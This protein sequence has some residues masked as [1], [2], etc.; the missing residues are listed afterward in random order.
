M[1]PPISPSGSSAAVLPPLP[2]NPLPP[3]SSNPEGSKV[4][5]FEGSHLLNGILKKSG[6]VPTHPLIAKPPQGEPPSRTEVSPSEA[7]KAESFRRKG[8]E[9]F[10]KENFKKALGYYTK[11]HKTN[12]TDARILLSLA[13][14]EHATGDL[15]KAHDHY[16]DLLALD[17]SLLVARALR[18][19]ANQTILMH[20]QR[21]APKI[22]AEQKDDFIKTGQALTLEM[23][24]D[25]AALLAHNI[26]KE[27]E[28]L[29]A[30]EENL[31][32]LHDKPKAEKEKAYQALLAMAMQ[33]M[34]L[35]EL[36][37]LD[38]KD[39][40]IIPENLGKLTKEILAVLSRFAKADKENSLQR[41]APLFE[42]Y[43]ALSEGRTDD[44]IAS[45]EAV[46]EDGLK[47]LGEGDRVKGENLLKEK[48]A[49]TDE[50]YR[51]DIPPGLADAYFYLKRIENEKTR[52][53]GLTATGA[54]EEEINDR[55][56]A[57][58]KEANG[59]WGQFGQ[60]TDLVRGK[61]TT[62]DRLAKEAYKE[63][64]VVRAVRDRLASGKA[65]TLEEALKDIEAKETGDLK[66]QASIVLGQAA[67]GEN[68]GYL[69]LSQILQWTRSPKMEPDA[70]KALLNS[71]QASAS[72]GAHPQWRR[73]VYSSVE[74]LCRDKE[75][76]D[77]AVDALKK[78]NEEK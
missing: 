72:P 74:T 67:R 10:K 54:W 24:M 27:L 35:A 7:K 71:V 55:Y 16:N 19:D 28:G 41:L 3:G 49:K 58:A 75:Q 57:K 53:V 8:D 14:A 59:F 39:E 40:K 9:Y 45:F 13:K 43:V 50:A 64:S 73:L 78:L 31:A 21:I 6:R 22:T 36:P 5:P 15:F 51:E 68:S 61:M 32:K 23:S 18:S 1:T 38:P 33:S 12:P 17:P 29:K 60:F 63:L 65:F 30:M 77:K 4:K 2:D 34:D 42:A 47:L 66:A 48:L 26:D 46:R 20:M 52:Q 62:H 25:R 11:A 70:A 56:A 44:A 69:P 37:A 76:K